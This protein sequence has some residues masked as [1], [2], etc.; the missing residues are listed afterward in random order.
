MR[1]EKGTDLTYGGILSFNT[2]QNEVGSLIVILC[3]QHSKSSGA[4][5]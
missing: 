5:N 1:N 3:T 2:W 4:L